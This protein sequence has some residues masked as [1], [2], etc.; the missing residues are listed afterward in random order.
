MEMNR[1]RKEEEEVEE[2]E[3]EEAGKKSETERRD[4]Y[5]LF[6]LNVAQLP[7]FYALVII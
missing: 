5:V 6:S 7:S 1:P 2:E 4:C 3:V